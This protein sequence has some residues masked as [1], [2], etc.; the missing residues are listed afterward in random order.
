MGERERE[1]EREADHTDRKKEK[2]RTHFFFT[3]W[4]SVGHARTS[5]AVFF[6][7]FVCRGKMLAAV[8]AGLERVVKKLL[9]ESGGHG[10]DERVVR[11]LLREEPLEEHERIFYA[12]DSRPEA[13][14]VRTELFSVLD[15]R[16]VDVP[17]FNAELFGAT[18][19]LVEL[20]RAYE[21][22]KIDG[23][24]VCN[25]S[26][27]DDVDVGDGDV[28]GGSS[29]RLD[30]AVGRRAL[31][32]VPL[33]PLYKRL[34]RSLAYLLVAG[35]LPSTPCATS[36]AGGHQLDPTTKHLVSLPAS[37]LLENLEVVSIHEYF[38]EVHNK[39][40]EMAGEHALPDGTAAT[41]A[42]N[43]SSLV[44]VLGVE[45]AVAVGAAAVA[46]HLSERH[47]MAL[48]G[49]RHTQATPQWAPPPPLAALYA[50]RGVRVLSPPATS[51]G[52]WCLIQAAAA[53]LLLA[54][55]IFSV[56]IMML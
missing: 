9:A 3:A 12:I 24:R 2:K 26:D 25:D 8:A 13:V 19:R 27:S 37:S 1:R 23:H 14:V 10:L 15:V 29:G 53:A 22:N 44:A 41:T 56:F 34:C 17:R 11:D 20:T 33:R 39:L 49:M 42:S 47:I 45:N 46:K 43:M 4:P 48:L 28:E 21:S 16:Q 6:F 40:W 5:L 32:G 18:R 50:V 38:V 31:R 55:T 30:S 52:L 35:S 36:R 54:L 7:F 51:R